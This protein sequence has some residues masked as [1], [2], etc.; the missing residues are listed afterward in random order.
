V[1]PVVFVVLVALAA[2]ASSPKP[3]ADPPLQPIDPCAES[4]P[5]REEMRGLD[6]GQAPP[7]WDRDPLCNA[8]VM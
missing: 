7:S 6:A 3:P 5:D 4:Y 2:C 1:R 8:G